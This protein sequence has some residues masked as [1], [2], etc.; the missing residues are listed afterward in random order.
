MYIY[1]YTYMSNQKY[2]LVLCVVGI[3]FRLAF[4]LVFQNS[5]QAM[6]A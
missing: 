4:L 6:E 1:I 3:L 5:I 2:N